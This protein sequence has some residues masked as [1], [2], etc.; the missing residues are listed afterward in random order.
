MKKILIFKTDR[1]GDLLNISPIINNIKINFPE[2]EIDLICSKY[3]K[4]IANYFSMYVNIF[5]FNKPFI[6]FLLS[7]FNKF[8]LNKYDLII[9]LDGKNHSYLSA[10]FIRS[11]KKICIQYSKLKS[12]FG[13]KITILRPNNIIN[14]FFTNS[15]NCTEDYNVSNNNDFHYLSLYLKLI[16]LEN[17]KIVNQDHFLPIDLPKRI[18]RFDKEY[19]YLHIDERWNNFEKKAFENISYA[20]SKLSTNE[21]IV[22]SSN[23]GGNIVFNKIEKLFT[24]VSN[25]EIIKDPSIDDMISLIYHSHTCVSSH[26]GLVVHLSGALKKRII[27]IVPKNIFDELD[28][29]IPFNVEYKRFDIL[30][31]SN[32]DL[33]SEVFSRKN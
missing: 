29:W 23:I 11:K 30:N 21:K 22:I 9:Q 17:I 28:R 2:C 6:F 15:L 4:S 24:N 33:C 14:F 8:F 10:I 1:L 13:K 32:L 26:S 18:P 25:I 5:V 27:D 3:N 16:S 12:I 19:F 31:F 7:N 20:I